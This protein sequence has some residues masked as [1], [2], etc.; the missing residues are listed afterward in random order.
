MHLDEG[1]QKKKKKKEKKGRK[2]EK[3]LYDQLITSEK[4]SKIENVL[5]FPPEK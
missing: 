2:K 3:Q 4:L 1:Y 5:T